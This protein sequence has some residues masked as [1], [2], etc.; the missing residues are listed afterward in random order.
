MSQI[1]GKCNY[2]SWCITF[3]NQY[4][5]FLKIFSKTTIQKCHQH[6]AV[7]TLRWLYLITQLSSCNDYIKCF[8]QVTSTIFG[9]TLFMLTLFLFKVIQV[10]NYERLRW[11]S[12][13]FRIFKKRKRTR[14]FSALSQAYLKRTGNF[15]A[16]M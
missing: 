12:L 16:Q 14:D 10:S 4:H 1:L 9:D 11:T 8:E 5:S 7:I 6:Q 2:I 15:N 3:F 13:L